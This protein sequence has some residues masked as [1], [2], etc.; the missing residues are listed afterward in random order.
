MVKLEVD[1]TVL[2]ALQRAFPTPKNSAAKAL[3]KYTELLESQLFQAL[4][5]GRTPDEYKLKLYSVPVTQLTHKGPQIG[6]K[7]VRLHPWLEANELALIEKVTVGSNISGKV[8]QIK[9][10][11]RVQLVDTLVTTK[12]MTTMT[13]REVDQ[14]LDGDAQA[15]AELFAMLFPD[16]DSNPEAFDHV[17]V[18]RTSLK[19]FIVWLDKE[20]KHYKNKDADL[21]RAKTILAIATHNKNLLPQRKVESDFGRTYYS[22]VNVQNSS[23][24]LRRAMLGNSW[25]YDMHSCA[26]AWKMGEIEN[27]I[28]SYGLCINANKQYAATLY[29]LEDKQ[30]FMRIVKHNTFLQGS[31]VAEDLQVKLIKQGLNA[32]G[33]GA[34]AEG[35]GW[36]LANGEW[37]NPAL[38]EIIKNPNERN[39]FLNC[40]LVSRFLAEQKE[41]DDCLM[42]WV[43]IE[44][45][46]LLSNPIVRNKRNISQPKVIA[47]L[48]QQSEAMVMQLLRDTLAL[49]GR[50]T[51][52]NIHDAFV[53][54]HRLSAEVKLD[55]EYVM[56]TET[57]N[58]H[59]RLGVTQ[60]EGFKPR[61]EDQVRD[62]QLHKAFRATELETMRAKIRER[63]RLAE[64]AKL[65]CTELG[66]CVAA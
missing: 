3:T 18:D 65:E 55:L 41:M 46:S 10:T 26:T 45:P 7:K 29:Y 38:S 58:P 56:Q 42:A 12:S 54:K 31:E 61:C 23:K 6:P 64:I 49:H 52:A 60:L 4:Q 37:K 20:S 30:E 24:T 35:K 47:F 44:C 15:N 53:V 1:T 62:E 27:L 32:L 17:P 14:Y 43:R 36:R 22:S 11:K 63:Q 48:Y 19:G 21:R 57:N 40:E 39:R 16:Y 25:E 8:S 59:W 33:F 34:K 2:E 13:D 28:R 51:I 66:S 5:R 50:E 9:L